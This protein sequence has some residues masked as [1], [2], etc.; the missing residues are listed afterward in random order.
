[1]AVSIYR[2]TEGVITCLV[3]LLD[4]FESPLVVS[5]LLLFLT[6]SPLAAIYLAAL[7]SLSGCLFR[8]EEAY[9]FVNVG[10]HFPR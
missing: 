10:A 4:G 6:G 7:K 3:L 9:N 2:L 8:L 1:M 5:I